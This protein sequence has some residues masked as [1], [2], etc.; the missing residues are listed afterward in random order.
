MFPIDFI[1]G[2]YSS[3]SNASNSI[4]KIDAAIVLYKF[5]SL[6]LGGRAYLR[7]ICT[8]PFAI[9]IF[10]MSI[11]CLYV[12]F[13][14]LLIKKWSKIRVYFA[15]QPKLRESCWPK[16]IYQRKLIL[17]DTI[18]RLCQPIRVVHLLRLQLMSKLS[19]CTNVLNE[20]FLVNL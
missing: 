14:E 7:L 3:S 11:C 9:F 4:K 13:Y 20:D 16:C 1:C 8:F 10:N 5:H 17:V 6:T 15:F 2:I 18:S 12:S 19:W